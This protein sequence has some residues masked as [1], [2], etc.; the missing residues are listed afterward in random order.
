MLNPHYLE[1]FAQMKHD[2][3]LAEARQE[4]LVHLVESQQPKLQQKIR[5][6]LGDWF[7]TLGCKLKAQPLLIV[8][9]QECEAKS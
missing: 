4:R 6:R 9:E 2:E 1:K 5:W 3:F 7:I 8:R